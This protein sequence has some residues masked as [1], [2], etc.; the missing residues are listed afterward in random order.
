LFIGEGCPDLFDRFRNVDRIPACLTDGTIGYVV[1]SLT[2]E[3]VDGLTEQVIAL[4]TEHKLNID[5]TGDWSARFH[6]T[7]IHVP[8]IMVTKAK[9]GV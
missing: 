1:P 8:V 4:I 5:L 9:G 7:S 6:G 3:E 2:K